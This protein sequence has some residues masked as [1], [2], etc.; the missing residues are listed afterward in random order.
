MAKKL[1]YLLLLMGL[2]AACQ[3]DARPYGNLTDDACSAPCWHGITPGKTTSDD[4]IAILQNLDIVKT[5]SIILPGHPW[6]GMD[7]IFWNF[8]R[9]GRGTIFIKDNRVHIIEFVPKTKETLFDRNEG[10]NIQFS[11]AIEKFGEPSSVFSLYEGEPPNSLG[12]WA[13]YPEKG[14]SFDYYNWGEDIIFHREL[15]S[16]TPVLGVYYYPPSAHQEFMDLFIVPDAF[17][18]ADVKKHTHPWNGYGKISEK[19]PV[20]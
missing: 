11:D 2:L 3:P 9:S 4:A 7:M 14:I 19:Y 15:T 8:Q 13:I 18:E 10:L 12:L 5:D 20:K 16:E 6:R 17:T 1:I